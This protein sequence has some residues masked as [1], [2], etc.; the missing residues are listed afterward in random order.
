MSCHRPGLTALPNH[1]WASSCTTVPSRATREY[2]GR[3]CVSSAYPTVSS[4]TIE[5]YE[6]NGY[7]ANV[8]S[9]NPIISA[10]SARLASVAARLAGVRASSTASMIG[11]PPGVADV[12]RS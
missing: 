8:A 3:V 1:W 5:P 10:C 6:T 7:G 11:R 2:T 9:R 12:R 4:S